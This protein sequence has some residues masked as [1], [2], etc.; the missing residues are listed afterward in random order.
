VEERAGG[1]TSRSR[2]HA[3]LLQDI[4]DAFFRHI[5]GRSIGTVNKEEIKR[6][7][8]KR[9]REL[10]DKLPDIDE[11]DETADMP[12]IN[13]CFMGTMSIIEHLYGTNSHQLKALLEGRLHAGK[14]FSENMEIAALVR[15]TLENIGEELDAD[16][17]RNLIS[18]ASGMV[19]GEMLAVAKEALRNGFEDVAAVLASAALEDSL[20]RKAED[21][22]IE[23]EGK[24]LDEV[25]NALKAKSFFKGPQVPVVSSYVKLRNAAMHA[26][27][28]NISKAEVS[29]LIG[30]LEPF[31]LEH[32]S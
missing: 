15:G 8:T 22:E 7:Y 6:Q 21:Y 2:L 18:E 25:I 28:S 17:I 11:L 1:N 23:A 30:F 32:F 16:L 19:I 12:T 24:S 26:E 9:I 29:S 5:I 13:G 14:T 20:K 31:L 27:W 4:K 3:E 10:L